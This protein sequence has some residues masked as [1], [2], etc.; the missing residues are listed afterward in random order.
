DELVGF[1]FLVLVAGLETTSHLMSK[2]ILTLSAHPE[3]MDELRAD[4]SLIGGFMHEQL[5]HDPPTHNLF[6]LTLADTTIAGVPIAAGTP[7]LAMVAAA[8][9]DPRQFSDPDR[10]DMRRNT[11]GMLSFGVGPHY[12]LGAALARL[13][14]QT[15]FEALLSRFK[16]F[17][18]LD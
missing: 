15:A 3:L 10:F 16:R 9:R 12:C 11:Q 4:P 5:R 2:A 14:A 18:R 8:N 6:R 7:V 1:L 13:E 17:E